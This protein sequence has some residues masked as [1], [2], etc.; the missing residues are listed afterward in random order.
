LK[1]GLKNKSTK[2]VLLKSEER[3]LLALNSIEC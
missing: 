2:G 1:Q 3:V